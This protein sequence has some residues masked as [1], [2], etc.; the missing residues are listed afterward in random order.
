MFGNHQKIDS[1]DGDGPLVSD[2][3]EEQ[4]ETES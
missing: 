2:S 3:Y 1:I 4:S